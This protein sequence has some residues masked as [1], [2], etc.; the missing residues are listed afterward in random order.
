MRRR[1][2]SRRGHLDFVTPS[3]QSGET[4]ASIAARRY[5]VYLATI[6]FAQDDRRAANGRARLIL[7]DSRD[8]RQTI[9]RAAVVLEL[10]VDLTAALNAGGAALI[11]QIQDEIVAGIELSIWAGA[12]HLEIS[13]IP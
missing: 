8:L 9:E 7:H 13:S 2:E 11:M 10:Y 12:A 4:E 5:R 3:V 6:N 1:H